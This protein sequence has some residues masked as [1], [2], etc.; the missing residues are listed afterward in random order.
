MSVG[1]MTHNT[2][3]LLVGRMF[4]HSQAYV[5]SMLRWNRVD[6]PKSLQFDV[7]SI[8]EVNISQGIGL[9]TQDDGNE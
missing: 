5:C 8:A 4:A 9:Q 1:M 7:Q 3:G 6:H 2:F